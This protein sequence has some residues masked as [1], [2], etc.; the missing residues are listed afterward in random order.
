MSAW[1]PTHEPSAALTLLSSLEQDGVEAVVAR[2]GAV[3]LLGDLQA[4]E[5]LAARLQPE[6]P[7]D[8]LI[9]GV[10][11]HVGDDRAVRGTPRPMPGTPRGPRRR[12]SASCRESYSLVTKESP[13]RGQG[14]IT[15]VRHRGVS[16]SE[17]SEFYVQDTG[18]GA[19]ALWSRPRLRPDEAEEG[20]DRPGR[21]VLAARGRDAEPG[22]VRSRDR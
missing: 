2:A 18:T 16:D 4:E 11:L 21:D 10:L 3:V 13:G 22:G 9:G 20:G 17:F 1:M 14:I 19:C 15:P 12:S 7:G 6:L 8:R 5:P